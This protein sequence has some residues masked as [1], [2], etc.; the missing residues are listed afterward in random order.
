MPQE[1]A[2]QRR[3]HGREDDHRHAVADAALG[4]HLAEPHQHRGA[5]DEGRDDQVAARPD[6]AGQQRHVRR[7][8]GGEERLPLSGSEDEDQPGRL[9]RGQPDRHVARVLRDLA[10]S[11]RALLLEFLELR[12]DDTQHLH[13]DAGGDVGH[14]PEREDRERL[15]GAAREEVEEA[16]RTLLVGRR[17]ELLDRDRVDTGDPN[18]HAQAVDGHHQDH[19]EELVAK[20]ADLEDVQQVGEHR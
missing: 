18:R 16:E 14:D 20:V 7:R 9:Q 6:S 10:L 4:D 8:A 13:D 11:D 5:G 12:N 1:A 3:H 17:P 2:R 15:E 19:E